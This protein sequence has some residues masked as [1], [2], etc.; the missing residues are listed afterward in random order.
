ML[1]NRISNKYEYLDKEQSYKN[2]TGEFI[3]IKWSL[4]CSQENALQNF[5]S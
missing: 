3:I 1:Y 2:S 4:Q 5:M